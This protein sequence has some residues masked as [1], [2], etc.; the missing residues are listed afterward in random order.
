VGDGEDDVDVICVVEGS[1][2]WA[3]G[4]CWRW[5]GG[6]VGFMEY[7]GAVDCWISD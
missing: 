6:E 4:F 7:E 2:V 5:E 1:E 3:V